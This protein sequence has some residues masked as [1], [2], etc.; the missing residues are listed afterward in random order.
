MPDVPVH[1]PACQSAE[2]VRDGKQHGPRHGKKRGSRTTRPCRASPAHG[3]GA[4]GG[5]R[6]PGGGSSG[7]C[8]GALWGQQKSA[9][10][11]GACARTLHGTGLRLWLGGASGARLFGTQSLMAAVWYHALVHRRGASRRPID[12][13]KHLVG[14]QP[15]PQSESQHPPCRAQ[16]KRLGR[17][18]SWFSQSLQRHALVV[19]VC[20]NRFAY[21]R[22]V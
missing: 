12:P 7:R 5:P 1:G 8:H 21:G 19:G 18:P 17:K 13:D 16:I 6:L 3:S 4:G 14:Q 10:G 22:A 2:G 11:V 15:T 20:I 9:A